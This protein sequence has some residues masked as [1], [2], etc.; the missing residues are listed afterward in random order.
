MI[1]IETPVFQRLRG[2]YLDDDQYRLLQAI[3]MARPDAGQLIRGSGGVANRNR[4]NMTKRNL[5]E[6]IREG[7]EAVRDNPDALVRHELTPPDVRAIRDA[8]GMSQS[9]MATFL[10]VSAKTLQNWEQGRRDPTGPAQTLL[11]VM[12]KEPEAV[13]RALHPAQ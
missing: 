6:E 11:R 12:E 3:L 9:Q 8:F 10:D 2:G 4:K 5:F 13:M 7:L 1:F